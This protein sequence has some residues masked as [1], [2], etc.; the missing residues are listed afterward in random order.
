LRYANI[1]AK[2]KRLAKQNQTHFIMKD[3]K[4]KIIRVKATWYV[5]INY[6]NVFLFA[7][8]RFI[9]LSIEKKKAEFFS[10]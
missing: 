9:Y 3:V 4:E 1:K 10:S 5:N 6:Q 7:Y 2:R 8:H